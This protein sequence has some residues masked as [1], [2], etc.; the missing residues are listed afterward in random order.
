MFCTVHKILLKVISFIFQNRVQSRD[1]FVH[2]GCLYIPR[3]F[4]SI[5]R[6]FYRGEL[7]RMKGCPLSGAA[8][9]ANDLSLSFA[10]GVEPAK[11]NGAFELIFPDSVSRTSDKRPTG[12]R[13][14]S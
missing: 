2:A 6:C 12:G 13:P 14:R 1:D 10:F 8:G 7:R 9:S 5:R 11:T 3:F 4:L